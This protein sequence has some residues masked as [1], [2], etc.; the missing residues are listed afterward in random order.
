MSNTQTPKTESKYE[1]KMKAQHGPAVYDMYRNRIQAGDYIAY[2]CRQGSN[3]YMRTAKVLAVK[4]RS[5]AGE[6]PETVLSVAMAKAPR[7]WERKAGNWDTKI[8]KTTVSVPYRTTVI[9]KAYVQ[10][11]KRY[12]CLLDV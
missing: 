11:D 8:V 5:L 2:P 1:V 4:E 6:K 12:A 9:P 3:T 10:N 7:D